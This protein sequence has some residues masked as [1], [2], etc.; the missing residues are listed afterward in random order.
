MFTSRVVNKSDCLGMWFSLPNLSVSLCNHIESHTV[1]RDGLYHLLPWRSVSALPSS[2]L[3]GSAKSLK[4]G[5]Q[6]PYFFATSYQGN[7]PQ[8]TTVR[9]KA[10]VSPLI[11]KLDNLFSTFTLYLPSI[12]DFQEGKR[13]EAQAIGQDAGLTE[14]VA[15]IPIRSRLSRMTMTLFRAVK[16]PRMFYFLKPLLVHMSI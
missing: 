14:R 12:P 1:I 2:N 9:E 8:R 16:E 10:L 5:V 6:R 7:M 4:A 11:L 15:P 13:I 3:C